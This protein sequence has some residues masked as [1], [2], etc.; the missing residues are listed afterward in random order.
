MR[1]RL[2]GFLVMIILFFSACKSSYNLQFKPKTGSRY[3]VRMT[4]NSVTSQD[5]GEQKMEIK[6]L[7]ELV[8]LYEVLNGVSA[9]DSFNTI[10]VTFKSMKNSQG[11]NGQNF[12]S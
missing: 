11:S 12:V 4:T 5:L 3:E 8:M 1:V 6:T 9:Q 7:T 10:K 2:A